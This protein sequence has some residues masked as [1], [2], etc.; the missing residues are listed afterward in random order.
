MEISV[1]VGGKRPWQATAIAVLNI[2]G[3]VLAFLFGLM[4][5]FMQGFISSMLSSGTD[6]SGAEVGLAGMIGSFALV[7]GIVMIGIGVLL[8]FMTR[9]LFRGQ[10][11][12]PIVSI[13][14]AILGVLGALS[15]FDSSTV[16]P[17]VIDAFILYCA[18]ICV[19]H[20]FFHKG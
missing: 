6:V 1:S 17:L 9:G 4:F 2:I 14:F 20:P 12:S 18:F 16:L 13:I 11:W 7:G 10:K 3:T 15:S 8:I 19:K 5:I